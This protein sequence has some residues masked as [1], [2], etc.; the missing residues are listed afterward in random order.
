[1]LLAQYCELLERWS[2]R[3]NLTSL[4]G[5]ALVQRL[6]VEPVWAG[7]EL[8]VSGSLAD[9]G[10]GNGSP[11]I[12]LHIVG[13]LEQTH[14]VE[15]RTKRAVFLRH[16]ITSLKLP[17]IHVH[18]ARF[19]DIAGGMDPVRWITLQGVK[20]NEELI[21]A[22]KYISLSTTTIVW[23]AAAGETAFRPFRRLRLPIT[24]SE[25]LLFDADLS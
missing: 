18:R 19:Q 16:V 12:P 3:I 7:L 20:L 13:R 2:P 1:L 24:G 10:S 9:I 4:R 21:D 22:I 14:L 25:V 17:G 8:G 11:A 6:V 23:F 15:T 5:L